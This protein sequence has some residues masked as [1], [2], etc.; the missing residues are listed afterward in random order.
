VIALD[1]NVLVRILTQDD[2]IQAAQAATLVD[3]LGPRNPAFL[4][5]EVLVELVWVLE[6][7]YRLSREDIADTLEH[8]L[9]AEGFVLETTDD[10]ANVIHRYRHDGY[11]FADLMILAAAKRAGITELYTFD[12]KAAGLPRA[13]LL[14]R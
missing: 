11:G 4:S 9:A 12:R 5:R 3:R 14:G 8:L 1:T 6:R 7:G 10:L 2:P 13:K